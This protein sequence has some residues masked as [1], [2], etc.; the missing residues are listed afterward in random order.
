M[1][2]CTSLSDPDSVNPLSMVGRRTLN[3]RTFGSVHG[4]TA[5]SGFVVEVG[6]AHAGDLPR[7]FSIS[8]SQDLNEVLSKLRHMLRLSDV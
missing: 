7:V 2:L 1:P 6:V 5:R 4:S 8:S 3:V